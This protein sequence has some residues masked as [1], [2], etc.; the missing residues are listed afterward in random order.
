[1]P[2]TVTL[3]ALKQRAGITFLDADVDLQALI[4]AS[5]PAL[6]YAL[7][8]SALSDPDPGLQAWLNLGASE[9]IA[10][11]ALDQLRRRPGYADSLVLTGVELRGPSAATLAEDAERLREQGWR[12]L[13][14]FLRLP[15]AAPVPAP[16]RSRTGKGGAP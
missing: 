15:D 5:L 1:M 9:V 16:V 6:S 4:D 11:D 12:R 8:A 14:P 10:A 7:L 13:R 2:L 3:A